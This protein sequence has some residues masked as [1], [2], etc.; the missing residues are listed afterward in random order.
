LKSGGSANGIAWGFDLPV[1]LDYN[2]G[3]K[4]TPD[5]EQTFGGYMGA[6]FSYMYTGW[7]GGETGK[8]VSYGPLA[9]TG[10]RFSS[11][12][13]SWSVTV[14]VYFKYGLEKEKYKT[15]GFNVIGDL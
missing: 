10:I 11:S 14:G 6:G 8:V 12:Q 3:C 7:S 15:F 1:A 5:N 9:L 13:A 4:S 2:I